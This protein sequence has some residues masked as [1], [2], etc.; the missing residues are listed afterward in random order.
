M[1]CFYFPV[2]LKDMPQ[3]VLEMTKS[4]DKDSARLALFPAM[5]YQ[6]LFN[7]LVLLIDD[8]VLIHSGLPG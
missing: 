3:D 8:A 1:I 4:L 5:D 6:D 2:V 7:I